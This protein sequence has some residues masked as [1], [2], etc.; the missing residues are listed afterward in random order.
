MAE[1]PERDIYRHCRDCRKP[2]TLTP[3]DVQW[4]VDHQLYLPTRCTDCRRLQRELREQQAK[5]E[6]D[7]EKW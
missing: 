7:L 5:A 1:E 2:F 3:K 4:F 6:R